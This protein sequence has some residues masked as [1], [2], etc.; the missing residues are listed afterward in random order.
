MRAACSTLL[1]AG[2]FGSDSSPRATTRTSTPTPLPPGTGVGLA[3]EYFA[4]ADL[5]GSPAL[6]RIDP[7]INF[8]WGAGSAHPLLGDDTHS[9][10]WTGQIEPRTS[11]L[12][13]F[14]LGAA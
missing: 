11:A 9:I 5:S 13:D 10:R 2:L 7:Q 4:S 3:A 6:V 14:E 8:D 12:Y 1:G